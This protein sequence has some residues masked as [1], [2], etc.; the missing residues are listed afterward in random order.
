MQF[1][2]DIGETYKGAA[3]EHRLLVRLDSEERERLEKIAARWGVPLAGAI[4]RLIREEDGDEP[5]FGRQ[6]QR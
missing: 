4:R 1:V 5:S 6:G 3:K 2:N